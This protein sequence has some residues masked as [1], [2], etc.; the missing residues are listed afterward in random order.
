MEKEE[1]IKEIERSAYTSLVDADFDSNEELRPRLIVNSAE[2]RTKVLTFLERELRGCQRFDFSVAFVT[3][4]G[5]NILLPTLKDLEARGVRGRVLTTNYLNFNE[6]AALRKL[7]QFKNLEV[8]IFDAGHFHS[9]GYIFEKADSFTFIIGSANLTQ[10]ALTLNEEW[11]IKI[12]SAAEGEIL[13]DTVAEFESVWARANDLTEEWIAEYEKT[14]STKRF[15][16]PEQFAQ[17]VEKTVFTPN[18]MQTEALANLATLREDP[19]VD[20]ALLISA[21]GTGKTFLSAFDAQAFF[22]KNGKGRLLFVVHREQILRSA[23]E[24]FRKVFGDSVTMGLF[25]GHEK[26]DDADFVFATVQTLSREEYL[27]WFK[28]NDFDYIVLDEAHHA[29]A[30]SYLRLWDYFQPKFWLGMTATPE[31]TIGADSVY[32]QFNYNIGYEIRLQRALEEDMLC[33]FHYFGVADLTIDGELVDD[34]TCFNSLVHEARVEN[35]IRNAEFYGHSGERVK[36]LIF[37]SRVAE[38]QRLSEMFNERGY[39]TACL[40][41]ADSQAA[42]NA[43]V[44]R[45]CQDEYEGGLDYVF[46]VD[47]FNEGVDLPEV[48]QILMVRPTESAIVFVQQLGRGLRKNASKEFVVVLDF[49][50]NYLNNF[51]IPIALSGDRTMTKDTLRQYLTAGT[52]LIPGCS[53]INF[54]PISQHVIYESINRT[55]FSQLKYLKQGY[56][57]LKEKTG[58]VPSLCDFYKYAS[59][60]PQVIFKTYKCYQDFLPRV[61]KEYACPLNETQLGFVRFVCKKISNCKRVHEILI[62]RLLLAGNFSREEFERALRLEGQ[63]FREDDF[64]SAVRVLAG[65]FFA[66]NVWNVYGNNRIVTGESFDLRLADEFVA[67]DSAALREALDDVLTY[68]LWRWRDNYREGYEGKN[69]CLYRKY[70]REDAVRL[71]NWEKDESMVIFGDPKSP[72]VGTYPIFVKY[73]KDESTPDSQKYDDGFIDRDTFRWHTVNG[74]TLSSEEIKILRNAKRDGVSIQL[75]IKK[76]DDEEPAS[77]FMGEIEPVDFAQEQLI[78]AKGPVPV[79]K[80][81]FRMK[82]QVREDI[83]EHLCKK[84]KKI[85]K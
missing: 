12:S 66:V 40:S 20:R 82:T 15:L 60:E 13:K 72:R 1:L 23:M 74:V 57:E 76:S 49:I 30:G 55:N 56:K 42:R 69:L 3:M 43:I 35:M 33:P 47:I 4:S 58:R 83:Y 73:E 36:G 70:T 78:S 65:N 19:E 50:G 9:K 32:K 31:R 29:T 8:K 41:G 24:T 6:P 62:L 71:L 45:L 46:T 79:V 39:R 17:T 68:A 27:R 52:M 22:E 54:D 67:A 44:Q 18:K 34:K 38:S 10:E 11:N 77:Y 53:V 2:R 75:F 81:I 28:A 84:F 21:T 63:E 37:C 5:L 85:E 64:L 7:L 26:V 51:L 59:I 61:E 25:T 14:Y 80:V 16:R 48:N